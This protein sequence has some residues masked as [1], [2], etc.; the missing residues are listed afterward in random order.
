MT[1]QRR[2]IDTMGPSRTA[3]YAA[4]ADRAMWAVAAVTVFIIPLI[5]TPS[6]W[7]SYRLPKEMLVRAA[8]ILLLGLGAVRV[9]LFGKSPLW[10]PDSRWVFVAVVIG[11]TMVTALT[12][13]NHVLAAESVL[14]VVGCAALY[15][16]LLSGIEGRWWTLL[17]TVL[18]AAVLNAVYCLV[19]V[20]GWAG[21]A[22]VDEG[23]RSFGFLGNADDEGSYL[24]FASIAAVALCVATRRRRTLHVV[25]AALL[26][27]ALFST[28]TIGA[29]GAL[30]A[31]LLI[32]AFLAAG[33]RAILAVVM[34]VTL[35]GFVA[36][37][38]R[39]LQLRIERWLVA[40][41]SGNI[42][43]ILSNRGAGILAAWE[44]F[45]DHPVAGVGPG[46]YRYEYYDY[47]IRVEDKHRSLTLASTRGGQFGEAH[48]DHLQTMAQT[49][50]PGYLLLLAAGVLVARRSFSRTRS[51]V[52]ARFARLT[53]LPLVVGFMVNAM[54]QFPLELAGP[55]SP[56]LA[57]LALCT[58]K[59]D[60]QVDAV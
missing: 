25:L 39:P 2:R 26:I 1:T 51:S 29:V 12:A 19:A 43:D 3:R 18:T 46:C 57:L 33:R 36:V 30:L 14:W 56:V 45:K 35:F 48:N 5:V 54:P 37:M 10:R 11:W 20:A 49:G 24:V 15:L 40:A 38:Y 53:A 7:D 41:G 59:F 9:L 50:L 4:L 32:F 55:M 6:T 21:G 22:G 16:T 52:E 13:Q 58:M 60:E 8:G 44:M 47:K 27:A 42:D 34:L 31:G 17:Y 23:R 28:Q